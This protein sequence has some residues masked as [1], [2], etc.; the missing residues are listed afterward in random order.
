MSSKRLDMTTLFACSD[1]N[2]L[3]PSAKP[4]FKFARHTAIHTPSFLGGPQHIQDFVF[5]LLLSPSTIWNSNL[6]V[7]FNHRKT[8]RNSRGSTILPSQWDYNGASASSSRNEDH[9]PFQD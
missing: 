5:D 4:T 8:S 9:F 1:F 2:V 3:S 6:L 7:F